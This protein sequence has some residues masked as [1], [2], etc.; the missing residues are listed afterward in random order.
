V[1]ASTILGQDLDTCHKKLNAWCAAG[2]PYHHLHHR[3][4]HT[5]PPTSSAAVT[6]TPATLAGDEAG[7][8]DAGGADADNNQGAAMSGRD[9]ASVGLFE[10]LDLIQQPPVDPRA[11]WGWMDAGA[12]MQLMST[13]PTHT[14]DPGDPP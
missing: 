14:D 6:D 5:V 3:H 11:G 13:A 9:Y 10:L 4:Q 12:I 7:A 1:Q 8:H 2:L